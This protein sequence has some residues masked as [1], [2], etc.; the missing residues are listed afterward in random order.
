MS[1]FEV[2]KLSGKTKDLGGFQV[3][4]VLPSLHCKMV[5][6]WIFFDHAGPAV[7][8][9]GKGIDVRPHP[10]INLATV[11][12]LFEGEFY[13]RDSIGTKQIIRPGEINLMVSGKGI[14]HSERSPDYERD[15]ESKL[16]ALQLWH[17]LP[18][19][20]EQIEPEFHHY[21]KNEIPE[22]EVGDVKVRVLI[23]EAYDVK[24]PVKT[25]CETLYLESYLQEN[26]NLEL[27]NIEEIAIYL[28]NGSIEINGE[29]IDERNMIVFKNYSEN[30]EIIAKE[31]SQ[32]AVIGGENIGKR[33]MDWNFVSSDKKRLEIAKDNWR[34]N[35]VKVFGTVIEDEEEFIPLPEGR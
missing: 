21:P 19:A 29:N 6:P 30:L 5:G 24:S 12:Y 27:P 26:D 10:H 15:N 11:T 8:E 17:A 32:I 31:E 33:Y 22:I 2:I 35:R 16:H 7:F 23:G 20:Y 25:F 1:E 18:E 14:S 34:N 4:R 28:V 3:N 9:A 13:H